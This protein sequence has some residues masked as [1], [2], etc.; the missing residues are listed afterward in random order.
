M[1]PLVKNSEIVLNQTA[2][3]FDFDF[4]KRT[5]DLNIHLHNWLIVD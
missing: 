3:E 1:A 4:V 2:Y 5:I